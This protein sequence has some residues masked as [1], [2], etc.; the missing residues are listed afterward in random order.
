MQSR[1]AR[2]PSATLR[3]IVDTSQNFASGSSSRGVSTD[4][5]PIWHYTE[6]KLPEQYEECFCDTGE[7]HGYQTLTYSGIEF[8][9][10]VCSRFY[11]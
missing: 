4:F 6:N 7:F 5:K 3:L 1:I 10:K 2:I 9:D 8:Y 11:G